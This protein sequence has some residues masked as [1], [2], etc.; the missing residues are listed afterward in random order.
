MV[1]A[2][3]TL[4]NLVKGWKNGIESWIGDSQSGEEGWGVWATEV[5]VI[6]TMDHQTGHQ[7]GSASKE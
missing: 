7:D 3:V 1:K 2:L 5:R 6:G 4:E